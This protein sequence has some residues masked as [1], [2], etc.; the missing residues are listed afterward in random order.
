MGWAERRVQGRGDAWQAAT[1]K[2]PAGT[3]L[4]IGWGVAARVAQNIKTATSQTWT[5]DVTRRVRTH[6]QPSRRSFLPSSTCAVLILPRHCATASPSRPPRVLYCSPPAPCSP[7]VAAS[8]SPSA[9]LSQCNAVT[10]K[11]PPS[12]C[13]PLRP[14]HRHTNKLTNCDAPDV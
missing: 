9:A 3:R 10:S 12:S 11:Q 5:G 14:A 13:H 2:G 6:H 8:A 1:R 7:T 4:A